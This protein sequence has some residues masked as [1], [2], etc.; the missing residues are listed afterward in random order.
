MMKGLKWWVG[1]MKWWEERNDGRT[2]MVGSKWWENRNDGR[3]KY[4]GR[5]EMVRGS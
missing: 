2:K 4:G 5:T 1:G 3:T